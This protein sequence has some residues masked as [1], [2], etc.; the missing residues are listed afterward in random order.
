[1][2][3]ITLVLFVL[4]LLLPCAA[5][6]LG[7]ISVSSSPAGA[8]IY[9]D[10]ENKG[11]TTASPFTVTNV[12]AGS[13][14]VVLQL[15]GYQNFTTNADVTD[16]GTYLVSA[17]L[18]PFTT[19]PT[20]TSISPAS[21]ANS[22]SQ[23]VE[24]VGT[25]FSGSTVTLT[26][27]DQSTVSSTITGTD[28]ATTIRRN[29]N[30]IGIAPGTWNLVILN[31]DG[32]TVTGSFIVNS[33]TEAT[34]ASIYPTSG[35]V[36]TSVSTT[37][38]GTGFIPTS[39]KIR[40]YR[41]GNYIGGTVNS[42]GT[43]TQLTGTFN[44]N[45]AT[46]GTYDVCV[47]PDGTETSKICDP[48]FTILSTASA[49]NG[50]INIISSPTSSKVF[51][52]NVYQGYTPL[53]LDDLSPGY[54]TILIQRAG[55]NDYSEYVKV[56]AGNISYVT[57]S[58]VLSP[59]VTITTTMVPRTTITTVKTT[60]RSTAKVPTPWPSD[61]PTLASPVGIAVILGAVGAGIVIIRK[62]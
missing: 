22:G 6:A 29:L 11:T 43:T 30:L 62:Q 57:A 48:T 5:S 51:R 31:S 55:Y 7:N 47:L 27:T 49:A 26:K 9:V 40:L 24:I 46:P 36:N 8:T 17:T 19:A 34:V 37:L 3:K 2:K 41:S 32:G 38:S 53:T 35:V 45:L 56:T 21:A 59:D 33:A 58:L 42:G 12:A 50:S 1:M 44:L 20:I 23:T 28:S 14:I 60:V 61:T 16:G 4:L 18:T 15:G 13:R 52:G 54:Y 39:A 10:N 25:G